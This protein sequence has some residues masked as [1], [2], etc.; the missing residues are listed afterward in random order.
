MTD[1]YVLMWNYPDWSGYGVV[2]AFAERSEA[3][4]LMA[5]MQEHVV[6]MRLV[7]IQTKLVTP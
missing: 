5:L 1:I 2:R 6:A 4:D 3:E 7:I